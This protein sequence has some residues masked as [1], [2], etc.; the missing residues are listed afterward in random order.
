M[1]DNKPGEKRRISNILSMA[2]LGLFLLL[3]LAWLLY[4]GLHNIPRPTFFSDPLHAVLILGAAACAVGGSL[5]GIWDLIRWRQPI[6]PIILSIAT[7]FLVVFWLLAEIS[8]NH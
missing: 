7:G 5:A 1:N 6:F 8:G 2:G 4:V 3:F